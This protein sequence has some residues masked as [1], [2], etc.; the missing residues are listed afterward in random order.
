MKHC[1]HCGGDISKYLLAESP[2]AATSS[3]IPA[4]FAPNPPL[5]RPATYDQTKVWLD[6]VERASKV[7]PGQTHGELVD[8]AFRRFVA[9]KNAGDLVNFSTVVHMVFDRVIVP[10]GGILYSALRVGTTINAQGSTPS[11]EQL[12]TMGY[13]ISDGKVV[14]VEGIPVSRAY[15]ALQYWGGDKQ[16]R[17]WH[18]ANPITVNPSR[19]GNPF[20]MDA[21][22]VAFGAKWTDLQKMKDGLIALLQLFAEGVGGEKKIIAN[23][24]A[25]EISLA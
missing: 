15:G 9:G 3:P 4:T 2:V 14:E 10:Q 7:Q 5:E 12:E 8:L 6:L 1:P 13:L 24:V 19:N 18:L 21:E 22:M 11:L 16:Y 20:F 23:A 25:V 17:R